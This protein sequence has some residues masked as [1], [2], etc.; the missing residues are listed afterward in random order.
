MEEQAD[1]RWVVE[2]NYLQ[3]HC[4]IWSSWLMN[5]PLWFVLYMLQAVEERR[6]THYQKAKTN[7]FIKDNLLDFIEDIRTLIEA[8]SSVCKLQ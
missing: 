2:S 5:L 3:L 4:V 1:S 8:H 6:T 7:E